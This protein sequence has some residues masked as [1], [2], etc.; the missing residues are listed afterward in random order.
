MQILGLIITVLVGISVWWWRLKRVK[1]MGDNVIDAAERF[2]GAQRRKKIAEQTG[3]SPIT[4]IEDPVTA[5][6][7]FIHIVIGRDVWPMAHGRVKARLAELS[8]DNLANE[9]V[10]YAEWAVRQPV[11]EDKAL[12]LL[13]DML[14]E[15]LTLEERQDLAAML[16][17]AAL[18]GDQDL[19][20]KASRQPIALVN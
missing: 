5:A 11:P 10:T 9:A 19:H 17:D 15:R 8:N 13:T 7:T 16:E 4:A 14:R 2:R 12:K 1:E 6:A 20:A 18:S 3:F